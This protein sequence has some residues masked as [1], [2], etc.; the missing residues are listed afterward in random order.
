MI[1]TVATVVAGRIARSLSQ[2]LMRF[3]ADAT[4]WPPTEASPERIRQLYIHIPFCA[5][6]C[7]FCTFHRVRYDEDRAT[8]YFAALRRELAWYRERGFDFTKLYIG[9]GTPTVN[10]DELESL[11]ADVRQMYSLT[12]I[13]VETNPRELTEPVLQMLERSGINRL[14]VGV[15]SFDDD[16]L[17]RMDR[18]AKYGS[19]AQTRD[20]LA[21]VQDRFETLNVDMMFNLPTQTADSLN[22]DL[23]ILTEE[24]RVDQVSY[25][26]LMVAPAA[27]R[28]VQARMADGAARETAGRE[29]EFY[30]MIRERFSTGY[31]LGSVWCFSRGAGAIDEYIVDED[32]YVGVGSGALSYVDGV[33]ASN[34]FSIRGYIDMLYKRKSPVVQTR[35][36]GQRERM[37]YDLLVKLFSLKMDKTVIEAKY[38][39]HFAKSM[40]GELALL[41]LLGYLRDDGE[42]YALTDRGAYLWVVLMREFLNGVNALRAEMRHHIRSELREL[43]AVRAPEQEHAA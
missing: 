26:P 17:K 40:R 24:L 43:D 4:E 11:L 33:A 42:N 19:G 6:L 25:Y 35:R 2:R 1:D 37:R 36:L 39:G 18:Y 34:T 7:P 38:S 23:R 30:R 12:E 32:D 13:S 28:S 27:R 14:S 41:R 22:E 29:R 5:Q 16:E 8:P 31:G 10:P 20:R 9:G 3:D 15:Q 21:A